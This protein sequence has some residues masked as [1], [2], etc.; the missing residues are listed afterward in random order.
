MKEELKEKNCFA[1][2]EWK[3]KLRDYLRW[4]TLRLATK[5]CKN[6]LPRYK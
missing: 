1:S 4:L 2:E 5:A 3:V 6:L